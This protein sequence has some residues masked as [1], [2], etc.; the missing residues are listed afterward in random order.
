MSVIKHYS[1]KINNKR[2][3]IIV[4]DFPVIKLNSQLICNKYLDSQH[5]IKS[6]DTEYG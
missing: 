2:V 3:L 6:I 5:S 4:V 1:I